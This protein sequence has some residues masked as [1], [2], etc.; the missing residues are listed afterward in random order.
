LTKVFAIAVL[1][2]GLSFAGPG[3]FALAGDAGRL[4]PDT[5]Q[6]RDAPPFVARLDASAP[7]VA[8]ARRGGPDDASNRRSF[9]PRP[10]RLPGGAPQLV[11]LAGRPV[12]TGRPARHT[13]GCPTDLVRTSRGPPLG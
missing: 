2:A 13:P 3:T 10:A 1:A 5:S 4:T 6:G 9:S 12:Q 7:R 8:L 11:A